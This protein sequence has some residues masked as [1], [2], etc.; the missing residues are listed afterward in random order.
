MTAKTEDGTIITLSTKMRREQLREWRNSNLFYCPGCNDTV[1]LKVG[2]IVI[3]HFAHKKDKSCSAS[4]SEGESKEHLQGKH[5]LFTFFERI[6]VEVKLEPYF[7]DLAQRPDLLV[8]NNTGQIP[9]EFQC[10]AIPIKHIKS[11]TAGYKKAGMAPIW[12]LHTPRKI[13]ALPQ[14]VG[15]FQLSEFEKSFLTETFPK[16]INFLTYNPQFERFHYFSSLLHIAG[17]RYIGLHRTLPIKKQIFPFAQPKNPNEDELQNYATLFLA[18]R[19]KFL[20][21]RILHNR[22]GVNDPFLRNCYELRIL[23]SELPLWI[24][25]PVTHINPF[26]EHPCEWQLAFVHFLHSEKLTV[27]TICDDFICSFVKNFQGPIDTQLI[28]CMN[29]R[30]FLL[31][32]NMESLDNI[33]NFEERQFIELLSHK[34]LAK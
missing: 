8:T 34:F 10:S 30:D 3:P 1:H 17:R 26:R 6:G 14:G 21:N 18:M 4:F 33:A 11:R 16:G 9:I 27:H 20:R 19:K 24:G 13:M 2:D 12:I 28:A 32:L 15:I 22:K 23:P 25:I 31:S 29:Y 7:N 5:D